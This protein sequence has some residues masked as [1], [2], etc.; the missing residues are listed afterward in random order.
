VNA[1]W[2]LEMARRPLHEPIRVVKLVHV[3]GLMLRG[4]GSMLRGKGRLSG[5]AVVRLGKWSW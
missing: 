5:T 4:K 1:I 3:K 2:P